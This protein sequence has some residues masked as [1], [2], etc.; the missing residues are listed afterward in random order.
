MK[1]ALFGTGIIGKPMAEKLLEADH[2]VI[3]Y[4]RTQSKAESL[5]EKGASIALSPQEAVTKSECVLLL[6]PDKKAIDQ[7]LFK[8]GVKSYKDKT[9]I[10]MGTICS[11]ES[12]EIAKK[13][14]KANGDYF[15]SPV[16]GSKMEAENA[17]LILMVGA[18]QEQF[19]KWFDLLKCFGPNPRLIGPIGHAAVLKLSLNHLIASHAACF[20]LSLGLIEKNNIDIDLFMSI[21]NESSLVAPMYSKKLNNWLKR[22]YENPNF[23]LKHLLKDV[24]L[25]LDEAKLKKIRT[26]VLEAIRSLLK[27]SMKE[28]LEEKDYSS[29][30]NTINRI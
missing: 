12:L 19:D 2:S 13:I 16:L 5:K 30:F 23:P 15:E 27:K 7:V 28:G 3:V 26:D 21:L 22:D 25:I 24:D 9:I 1:V 6:L 11:S 4:N 14:L 8:S 10:Q 20:S 29:V 17:T 18:S